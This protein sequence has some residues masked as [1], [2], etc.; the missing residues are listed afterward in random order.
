[1]LSNDGGV[2]TANAAILDQGLLTNRKSSLDLLWSSCFSRRDHTTIFC[3]HYLILAFHPCKKERLS[4]SSYLLS[5]SNSTTIGPP[6]TDGWAFSFKLFSSSKLAIVCQILCYLSIYISSILK[7]SSLCLETIGL[8]LGRSY[9]TINNFR[10]AK[11]IFF[12]IF[13]L[14]FILNE[15]SK[16]FTELSKG[17]KI[18]FGLTQH[19]V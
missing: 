3:W 17:S 9:R 6:P 16:T 5:R 10:K 18:T 19:N 11:L 4:I 2:D 13:L 12:F 1:M 14:C 8:F 7:K 15:A